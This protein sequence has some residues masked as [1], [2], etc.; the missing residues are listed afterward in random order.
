MMKQTLLCALML[1]FATLPAGAANLVKTYSYFSV[2]GRTLG[3]I[4]NQLSK[5]GPEVKSTGSRHPGAT[6]MAFTTRISYAQSAG[7][8]RIAD[9]AVTVKVKV[10]LPE[11][12]RPRK[13]DADVRLFWDTLSA[14]IKRHEERHVE[15]AKNHARLLEDALKAAP[16]QK[17]CEQAKAKAAAIQAAELAMHDQDQV[18]FDRVEGVNFESRILRLMRY[19]MQRVQAGQLPPP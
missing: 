13:S 16:P 17:T 8:C 18:R 1:T 11:W 14:D 12:R 5:N 6:K 4:Q 19:R 9:A 15:I 3:D 2:G 7:S 10:I